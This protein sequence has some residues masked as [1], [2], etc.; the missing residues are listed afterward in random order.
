MLARRFP[1]PCHGSFLSP[2]VPESTKTFGLY[3]RVGYAER[4]AR[5]MNVHNIGQTSTSKLSITLG[6]QEKPPA[7][8]R[9]GLC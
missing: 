8:S 9:R 3:F 2:S 1:G 7:V 6:T 4:A 5:R